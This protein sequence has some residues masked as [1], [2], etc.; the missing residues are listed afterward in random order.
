MINNLTFNTKSNKSAY[1][2]AS[3]CEKWGYLLTF[4]SERQYMKTVT[5]IVIS[6]PFYYTSIRKWTN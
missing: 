4:I 3:V 2:T 6:L 1:K 5:Y